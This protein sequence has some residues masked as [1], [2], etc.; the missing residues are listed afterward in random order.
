MNRTSKKLLSLVLVLA[1][2]L[3]LGMTAFAATDGSVPG[4]GDIN[5]SQESTQGYTY[6]APTDPMAVDDNI[7]TASA[8]RAASPILGMMGLNATSGFGMINGGAP[9]DLADAET[10]FA[11]GVWGTGLNDSPDPYY[12]NYFYNFYAEA[13]GLAKSDD[14]LIN[15]D[16]AASPGMADSNLQEEYGNVSYSLATRPQ[17]L[18]GVQARG[19]AADDTHGYD[20]QLNT[21]HGFT[22]D[23]PYYQN[24]DEAYSP[25]L[26]SYQFTYLKDMIQSVY[27]LADAVKEVEKDTGKTTRYGDVTK[28]AEHYEKYVYGLIAYVREEL[29]AKG[30]PMKTVAVVTAINDDGTYT[31]ADSLSRSATSLVRAYEYTMCVSE[32]LVDKL[33]TT[34]VTLDQL[35]TADAIVTINNQN[36]SNSAMLES[37]GEKTYNGILVASQ[38]STLYGI[39]MN[40]VENAMGHAYVV[41]SVYSDVLDLDPVELCAYFYYNFLHVSD[42][43]SVQTMISTNFE[44]TILPSGVSTTLA[45]GY[46]DKVAGQLDK[47]EAYFLANT[48]AFMGSAD[49]KIGISNWQS[50]L[51]LYLQR[52]EKADPVLAGNYTAGALAALAEKADGYAYVYVRKDVLNAVVATEYV[53][54]SALLAD[55]GLTFGEGDKLDI[56]CSDGP[57]SKGDFSYDN[58]AARGY[59]AEGNPVPTGLA[60]TWSSGSLAEG[61]VSDI[62]AT[63]K[64]TG[65]IRFVS[66]ATAAELEAGNAAGNRMPSGVVSI[67]LV[68]KPAV[69]LTNQGLTVD[70]KT[71]DAM[72]IYNINDEN[73]FKLRDLAALLN[74]TGSQFQVEYNEET[75]VISVTTGTAYTPVGGEL[76]TRAD[77]SATCKLSSQ[78]ITINGESVDLTAYNLGGNN[79]FRLRDLDALLG[80]EVGYDEVTRTMLVTS[81]Q[82]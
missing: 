70:G 52:G 58:I 55:A 71:I 44:K 37:F 7:I 19:A 40:S 1:M 32:S 48:G 80:Y 56:I 6:S 49:Q 4:G 54:L 16:V 26:I 17:L 41:G 24:G 65:N 38:P 31:L 51:A 43:D 57:Y 64:N 63:A 10:R 14:A 25:K 76:S 67:T 77:Q 79:F 28:I 12:W 36:I 45:A 60:L 75:R 42:L 13:N 15:A 73:Y 2:L 8:H 78:S 46:L 21:I 53:S 18:I 30:L 35:L 66:G 9:K 72:E 34:T 3:S 47:G 22:K 69:R 27:R 33:G 61:T 50:V 23:R 62:A 11:L 29:A 82:A 81:K 59:D 39:T 68:T 5:A 20:E 74:G